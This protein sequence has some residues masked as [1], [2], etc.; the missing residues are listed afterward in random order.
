M[1][2]NEATPNIITDKSPKSEKIHF[3]TFIFYGIG[4]LSNG[5]AV[6]AIGFFVLFYTT[7]IVGMEPSDYTVISIVTQVINAVS[8]PIIGVWSDRVKTRFGRRR[9]FILASSVLMGLFYGL[10]FTKIEIS[11]RFWLVVYYQVMFAGFYLAQTCFNVPHI[12]LVMELTE[13][14]QTRNKFVAFSAFFFSIGN[15]LGPV[16]LLAAEKN[17]FS[18][19][20]MAYAAMGGITAVVMALCILTVFFGLKERE[21][22]KRV[23]SI[24]QVLSEAISVMKY[25]SYLYLTMAYISVQI[26]IQALQFNLRLYIEHVVKFETFR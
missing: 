18:D 17:L 12:A 5:W 13:Q 8:D 15:L 22:P 24:R 20:A 4:A 2:D 11:N 7:S 26:A 14:E 10:F 23:R 19:K 16:T 6:S 25:K 3:R 9:P 1:T 21:M